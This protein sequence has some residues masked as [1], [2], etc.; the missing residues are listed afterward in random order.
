ML[1][2]QQRQAAAKETQML[3]AA[4]LRTTIGASDSS[5]CYTSLPP[6]LPPSKNPKET[7]VYVENGDSLTVANKWKDQRA[8]VGVLNMASDRHPGGGWLRG[9]LAQE[10]SLCLR[11]TLA[12]TLKRSYYPLPQLGAI[13]SPSVV[14]FRDELQNDCRMLDAAEQYQVGVVSVPGLRRPPLTGDELD[15]RKRPLSLR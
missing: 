3:T 6:P 10:E 5:K 2:R 9:A 4:I 7:H 12:V 14:V 1:F 11:S 8:N 15:Y 13:W